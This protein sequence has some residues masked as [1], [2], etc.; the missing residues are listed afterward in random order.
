[1]SFLEPTR[2]DP[3]SFQNQMEQ[4]E[5]LPP[6]SKV[7]PNLEFSEEKNNSN[8]PR[9]PSFEPPQSP[10]SQQQQQQQNNSNYIPPSYSFFSSNS[11]QGPSE[12]I[13]PPPPAYQQHEQEETHTP[14]SYGGYPKMTEQPK[15]NNYEQSDKIRD[16]L[17]YNDEQQQQQQQQPSPQ[18]KPSW[19]S[20]SPYQQTLQQPQVQ[21][22]LQQ[23]YQSTVRPMV[24]PLVPQ[25]QQSQYQI[26]APTQSLVQSSPSYP[27]IERREQT[28]S[29]K[30]TAA[31]PTQFQNYPP[32]PQQWQAPA[33]GTTKQEIKIEE[34]KQQQQ[35][36]VTMIEQMNSQFSKIMTFM[37]SVDRRL[38]KLER[39]T[40]DILTAQSSNTAP[41]MDTTELIH[42]TQQMQQLEDDMELARQLQE[43]LNREDPKKRPTYST[44][45]PSR[46][47]SVFV[48][49][50]K[51]E[52]KKNPTPPSSSSSLIECPVCAKKVAE[53]EIDEHVNSCLDSN[54]EKAEKSG[55][56]KW[57]SK[58][59]TPKPEPKKDE[60]KTPSIPTPTPTPTP[61]PPVQP[62]Y[63]PYVQPPATGRN[64][65]PMQ[66]YS[67]YGY[68][69]YMLPNGQIVYYA[70]YPNQTNNQK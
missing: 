51:E 55:I 30:P 20:P 17:F 66:M 39:S 64:P 60:K 19:P 40:Q 63:A 52:P 18:V 5:N 32:L 26:Q 69:S 25:T 54:P 2:E 11:Q 29:P 13:S 50:K 57:L 21:N 67:Q 37:E 7:D 56:L 62:Y 49:K 6:P 36:V 28:I 35:Q 22:Q 3:F 59:E 8:V 45:T 14:I 9:P 38:T 24:T 16:I 4:L 23:R 65:A 15:N 70:N 46:G 68:P 10:Q 61:T 33:I 41:I 42:A 27:Q 31:V 12:H 34:V 58:K 43:E 53:K 47:Q 48:E 1:M 44:P